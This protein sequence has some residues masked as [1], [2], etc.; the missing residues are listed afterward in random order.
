[1]V[2]L[3]GHV[4]TFKRPSSQGTTLLFLNPLLDLDDSS[5][6]ISIVYLFLYS[7][8]RSKSKREI[9]EKTFPE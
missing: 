1:M 5:Y 2:W 8:S 7:K 9:I 6:N 3:R 4:V